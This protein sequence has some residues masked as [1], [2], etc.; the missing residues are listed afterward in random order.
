MEGINE[1]T[2]DGGAY[3]KP[4][5]GRVDKAT[6]ED[7]DNSTANGVAEKKHDKWKDHK[8]EEPANKSPDDDENASEFQNEMGVHKTKE[9]ADNTP[10]AGDVNKKPEDTREALYRLT[11][12][13]E[14]NLRNY[15]KLSPNTFNANIAKRANIAEI[16]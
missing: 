3:K 15:K 13:A 5:E 14:K 10:A 1:S 7:V 6:E 9:I 4:E 12:I 2:V 8:S 11:N 16:R